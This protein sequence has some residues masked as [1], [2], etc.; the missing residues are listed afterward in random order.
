MSGRRMYST[1]LKQ[2]IVLKYLTGNI[3][4]KALAEEYHV[5]KTCIQK[6]LTLYQE[7]GEAGLCTRHGTYSGDFKVSVVEHN[8]LNVK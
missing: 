7:H 2:E 5:H 6:W 4:L 1:E 3:G 8:S